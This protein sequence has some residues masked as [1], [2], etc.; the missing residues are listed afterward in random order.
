MKNYYLEKDLS[1]FQPPPAWTPDRVKILERLIERTTDFVVDIE[2]SGS[3]IPS[4]MDEGTIA[5]QCVEGCFDEEKAKN[6]VFLHLYRHAVCQANAIG[7]L[8]EKSSFRGVLQLWRSL[9][10]AYTLCKWF[11]KN[12]GENPRLIQ[13]YIGHSL[14]R[15]WITY[16]DNYN[17]LCKKKGRKIQYDESGIKI[18]RSMFED[19]FGSYSDYSWTKPTLG[20]TLK[21]RDLMNDANEEDKVLYRLSSQEIHP[22]LGNRFLLKGVSLPLQV[23]PMPFTGA[24]SS[25]DYATARTL[26]QMTS[27]V[28]DFLVL[29]KSL[30]ERL[31]S[32]IA[33]TRITRE[34]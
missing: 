18:M 15:S 25:L 30:Q 5:E 8:I 26:T 20:K 34:I 3:F 16:M 33:L 14:L 31:E 32:L 13:D 19:R 17:K 10:E 2:R 29:N 27:R 1:R 22:T 7:I 6:W 28:S 12:H 21:F 24:T 9:F 23:F 11:A 4:V